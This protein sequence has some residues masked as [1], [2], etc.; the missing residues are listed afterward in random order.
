[1]SDEQLKSVYDSMS[2]KCTGLMIRQE[3]DNGSFEIISKIERLKE[4]YSY[5]EAELKSRA[6]KNTDTIAT[7]NTNAMKEKEKIKAEIIIK[8]LNL[9]I[10]TFEPISAVKL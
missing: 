5:I 9:N 8:K 7:I 1:M 2:N 3:I 4:K 6:I 10:K